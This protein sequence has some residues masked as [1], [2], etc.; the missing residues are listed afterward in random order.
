MYQTI[1]AE[2][3]K[4]GRVVL[5]EPVTLS[6]RRR[7]VVTILEPLAENKVEK[8]NSQQILELLNSPEF[9]GPPSLSP[10]EMETIIQENRNAWED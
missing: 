9:Q 1:E 4:D 7:A 3:G 5:K 2:I 6:E 8:G 10:E